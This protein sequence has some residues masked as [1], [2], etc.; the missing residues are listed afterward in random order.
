VAAVADTVAPS[1]W[2]H[3]HA[4]GGVALACALALAAACGEGAAVVC[5]GDVT[6]T[7]RE[8]ALLARSCT[9][10]TGTLIIAWSDVAT[11]DLPALTTVGGHVLVL[12]NAVLTD[13]SLPVLT[14]VG[15]AVFILDNGA[16]ANVSIPALDPAA[17]SITG[18]PALAGCL[19]AG[20]CP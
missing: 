20:P 6:L 19:A 12:E 15:G 11:V 4:L 7:T 10:I 16:L 1:G 9:Y 5:T 18:S 3:P 2:D 8:D 13:V 17:S 14:T